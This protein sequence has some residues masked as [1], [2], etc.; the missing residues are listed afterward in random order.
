MFKST[1]KS[2]MVG[3]RMKIHIE[4]ENKFASPVATKLID[5]TMNL[6]KEPIVLK[7]GSLTLKI[8]MVKK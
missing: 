3:E 8:E 5:E 6:T 7:H 4:L 2:D 1:F